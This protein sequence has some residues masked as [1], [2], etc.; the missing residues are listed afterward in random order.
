VEEEYTR[1]RRDLASKLRELGIADVNGFFSLW[2]WYKHWKENGLASYQSR[3]DY[4]NGLYKP[5]IEALERGTAAEPDSVAPEEFSIRH[6]YTNT[7]DAEIAIREEAPAELR[8]TVLEIA[9]QTGWDYDDLLNVAVRIGK[10]PWE[11]PVPIESRT[12]PRIQIQKL[13]AEWEWY[14]VYDFIERIYDRMMGWSVPVTDAGHPSDDFQDLLNRYFR[15]AGIG[16]QLR[17]NKIVSR[18]S[19]AF[20]TVIRKA[21]PGAR[22]D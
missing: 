5:L 12:Q 9:L 8:R 16:W 20:E 15:Y 3:R 18:G 1:V 4:I 22:G 7:S 2:D 10:Q 14:Q 21:A 19:E 11:L 17:G 13:M 6:G